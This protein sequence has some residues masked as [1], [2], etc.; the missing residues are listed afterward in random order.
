MVWHT[1]GHGQEGLKLVLRR[2]WTGK[3]NRDAAS[4]EQA[5]SDGSADGDHGELP[6]IE[7]ALEFSRFLWQGGRTHIRMRHGT[8]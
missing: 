3:L 8:G 7:A 4:Q 2:A 6:G 1:R 5:D